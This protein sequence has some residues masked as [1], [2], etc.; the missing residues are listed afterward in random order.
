MKQVSI[1][2]YKTKIGELILASYNEQLCMLDYRYRKMRT[3]VD[4]RIKKDLSAEFIESDSD[5]LDLARI[6]IEEY[7]SSNRTEFSLPLLMVGSAFQQSVWQALMKIPYGS[8]ISY[9]E[10]ATRIGKEKSVRAV[11]NANG[12]NAMSLIIPCHRV[13]GSDGKLVGYGGGLPI[14]QRLLK[15]EWENLDPFF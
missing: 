7:L 13:I 14:K 10:L 5:V 6:Q 15:M 8:T 12:A 2:Y 1:Q 3:A 11:A 9:L 4:N